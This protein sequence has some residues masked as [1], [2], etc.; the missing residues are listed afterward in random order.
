VSFIH[1]LPAEVSS[2][3]RSGLVS[4]YASLTGTGI[5]IDTP[6]YFFPSADEST[7]DIGTGLAYPAKAERAR[8]NSRVGLLV[9]RGPEEPPC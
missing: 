8:R 4:E 2:L 5:P 6:T 9:Q 3:I 1:D 7:L